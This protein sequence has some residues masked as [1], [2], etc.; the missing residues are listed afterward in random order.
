MVTLVK[1]AEQIPCTTSSI[2]DLLL[3]QIDK[4]DGTKFDGHKVIAVTNHSGNPDNALLLRKNYNA[5][6]V[7]DADKL[8]PVPNTQLAIDIWYVEDIEQL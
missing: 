2:G 5:I 4:R 3:N 8:T 7:L 6:R 1:R